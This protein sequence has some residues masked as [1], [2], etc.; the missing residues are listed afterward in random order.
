MNF[1][2][3]LTVTILEQNTNLPIEELAVVLEL[4]AT[5]KNNYIIGPFVSDSLGQVK[6]TRDECKRSIK[7]DK[8]MF[9]MDY[10]DDLEECK[11]CLDVRL[12]S[13]EHIAAMLQQYQASPTFWG[14]RFQNATQLFNTLA[15]VKN[16]SFEPANIHI[17]NADML[18][19]PNVTM[20]ISRKS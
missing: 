1:P 4:F 16:G 19:N 6:F 17:R 3:T 9:L 14:K 8:E 20:R 15:H 5:R 18:A 13:P 10:I 12:H 2:E 7:A 11:Q